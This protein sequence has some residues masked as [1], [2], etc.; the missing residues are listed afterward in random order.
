MHKNPNS[1]IMK[2]T[3][4]SNP[5][6]THL[7]VFVVV[8]FFLVFRGCFP[9]FIFIFFKYIPSKDGHIENLQFAIK[10]FSHTS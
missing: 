9:L 10:K 4:L 3:G 8:G 7:F 2:D 5:Y 1:G 6:I